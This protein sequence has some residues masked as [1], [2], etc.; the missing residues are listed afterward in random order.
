MLEIL[1]YPD[2]R[3]LLKAQTVNTFDQ[4]LA[5]TV[6]QMATTMYAANGCGLA[7]IQVN[8]QKSITVIDVSPTG[9]DLLVL[10]NPVIISHSGKQTGM[11]GCLSFPELSIKVTR[12]LNLV[13]KAQDLNGKEIEINASDFLA[14]CIHH[15]LEH[16][17]GQ[18]FIKDLSRLKLN[19]ALKKLEKTKRLNSQ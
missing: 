4:E 8:I 11:E 19:L 9:N 5:D 15:E 6:E 10:I 7:S 1:T 18:V 16:L 3:L 2:P 17:D 14:K 12:P 13:V